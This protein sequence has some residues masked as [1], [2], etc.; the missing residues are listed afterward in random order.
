MVLRVGW[1]KM[2]GFEVRWPKLNLGKSWMV[3]NGLFPLKYWVGLQKEEEKSILEE[4][5]EAMKNAVLLH[6]PQEQEHGE[7]RTGIVLLQ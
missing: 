1:S 3:K 6:Q 2:S 7:P 5:A 4:G